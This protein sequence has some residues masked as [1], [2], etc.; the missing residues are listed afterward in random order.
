LK[1]PELGT[2]EINMDIKDHTLKLG[3]ITEHHA[4][5]E[6]LLNNIHELKEA[7]LLQGVKLEKVDVQINHNFGQSLSGSK[8]GTNNGHGTRKDLDENPLN[9]DNPAEGASAVPMNILS[10][11]KLLDLVA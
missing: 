10:K 5:R 3:L 4:A 8:E 7:L 6:L 11:S 1:P 2:V 9:S